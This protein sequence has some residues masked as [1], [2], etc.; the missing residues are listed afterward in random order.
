MLCRPLIFIFNF[1][2]Y[3]KA[4]SERDF[5]CLVALSCL[6]LTIDP[7][8]YIF[9]NRTLRKTALNM[10]RCKSARNRRPLS[11]SGMLYN[12]TAPLSDTLS[13]C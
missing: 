13:L 10:L 1:F 8:L 7:L 5:M 11:R 6:G 4:S 3:I 9:L 12:L 2:S